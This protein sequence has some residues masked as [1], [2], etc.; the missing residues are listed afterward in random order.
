MKIYFCL[1]LSVLV[2]LLTGCGSGN[3]T[4]NSPGFI[5]GSFDTGA[6]FSGVITFS[7]AEAN[8]QSGDIYVAGQF[9]SYNNAV[10]RTVVRLN[11]N[12]SIDSAFDAGT[13]FGNAAIFTVATA[14]DGSGD[15]Y[16]GGDFIRRIVRLNDDGSVDSN[17]DTGTGFSNNLG[18][19]DSPLSIVPAQDG[20]GDI[21][22]AGE[23]TTYN[24]VDSNHIIRLNDDG[25]ID[26]AFDVGTGF[27]TT[28]TSEATSIAALPDGSGIYV[29]GNF[30]SYQGTAS[31]SIILL[32]SDGSINNGFDVGS[33]FNGAVTTI[34][35]AA[36][37]DVYAG[38]SFT[39]YRLNNRNRIARINSDG[40]NDAGFNIAT[41][42]DGSVRSIQL[43]PDTSEDVIV[44]GEFTSYGGATYNRI[45]RLN[46][47]GMSGGSFDNIAGFNDTVSNILTRGDNSGDIY[48]AG[49]FNEY[50]NATHNRI[51]RIDAM[52]MPN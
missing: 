1:I 13:S 15:I 51:I 18:G 49:R 27:N 9:T 38:G 29:G 37:D 45:I 31:N 26:A 11:A 28:L 5:T 20:S 42:F 22:V 40:S 2:I 36:N 3:G 8:D 4:S 48:V 50:N 47:F 6:G 12:G 7:I 19:F 30:T 52:G 33:G 39:L 34:A 46:S 24:G 35:I 10:A 23:F 43:A 25:S 14:L 21:Y 32:N 44:G 17:F 16:I 41:G